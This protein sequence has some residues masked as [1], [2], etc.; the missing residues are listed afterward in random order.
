MNE[1]TELSRLQEVRE[2]AI[3]MSTMG[4]RNW[5]ERSIVMFLSFMVGRPIGSRN[6]LTRDELRYLQDC[7]ITLEEL[8]DEFCRVHGRNPDLRQFRDQ[9]PRTRPR[10]KPTTA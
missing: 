1:K 6:E 3:R 5:S 2:L 9:I 10:R 7:L 8:R 4:L